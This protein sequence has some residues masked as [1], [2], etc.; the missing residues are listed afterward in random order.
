[1]SSNTVAQFAQELKMPAD[2]LLEQLRA[3]G[4]D[5]QTVDDDVTEADKGKLLNALR[6]ASSRRS[7]KK[8]TLTR[9]KTS[10]IRQADSTGRSRSIPVEVRR[11][12]VFVKR[13]PAEL[14]AEAAEQAQEETAATHNAPEP[15]QEAPVQEEPASA[16][17][18]QD[19]AQ[20]D[21]DAAAAKEAA[22]EAARA[23]AE[24]EAAALRAAQEAA[25][26]E[27]Q[28]PQAAPETEPEP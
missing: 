15:V 8:I 5:I 22:R 26:R 25:R 21:A 10:E 1:M 12:R 9:K 2:A 4:V 11:K 23:K 27:A 28:A 7:G 19:T 24:E 18:A 6:S 20:A 14:A 13:S 16:A 3:A 17:P